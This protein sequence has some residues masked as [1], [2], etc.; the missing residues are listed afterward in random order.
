MAF[1]N[2]KKM[3]FKEKSKYT[4]YNCPRC[5]DLNFEQLKLIPVKSI[6]QKAKFQNM[7]KK[8]QFRQRK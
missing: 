3:K 4:I 8:M 5:Q 2:G 7:F 1:Q 6:Q